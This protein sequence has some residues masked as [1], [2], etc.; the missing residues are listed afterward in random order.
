M[1]NPNW[2]AKCSPTW[3]S[4]MQQPSMDSASPQLQPHEPRNNQVRNTG[5][6]FYPHVSQES[7]PS[8]HTIIRESMVPKSSNI[9]PHNSNHADLGNSFLSLLSGPPSLL[10]RDLQQFSSPGAVVKVPVSSNIFTV[11]AAGSGV[12]LACNGIFSQPPSIENPRSGADQFPVVASRYGN[13][14]SLLDVLQ[15]GNVNHQSSEPVKA[16]VCLSDARNEKVWDF[17]S[18][19]RHSANTGKPHSK[20]TQAAQK[21]PL[22]IN[23]ST[24]PCSYTL[25]P[26]CPRVFCLGASGDLLRSD[27]GLLG[28]VCSCHGLRMS[29]SKFCQHSGVCDVNPGAAVH[30][31]SGETIAQWRKLYFHKFGIRVPED[32]N[33]WDWPEGFS[34]TAGTVKHSVTASNMPKMSDLSNVAGSRGGLVEHRQPQHNGALFKNHNTGQKSV[35]EV[36]YVGKQRNAQDGY[37]VLHKG[38][39]GASQSNFPSVVN[40]QIM[41]FHSS[42]CSTVSEFIGTR[43]PYD[44][45][46]SVSA[47]ADSNSKSGQPFIS[48][49][50]LQNSKSHGNDS[51]I[52][53]LYNL[54]KGNTVDIDAVSSGIELKLGQPSPQS[55]TLGT[56]V[57]P[58]F[59]SHPFDRHGDPRKSLLPEQLIHN[60]N[61]RGMQEHCQ[62]LQHAAGSSNTC[63]RRGQSRLNLV[64]QS[65]GI[66]NARDA[67]G[68]G[69]LNGDADRCSMLLTQC[70]TST[71]GRIYSK[72]SGGTMDNCHVIPG[73]LHCESHIAK[74]DSTSSSWT[75]GF[76]SGQLTVN[77][78]GLQGHGGKAKEA[79]FA[80][81]SL[82]VATEPNF[83]F[84]TKHRESSTTC[85]GAGCHS[86]LVVHDKSSHLYKFS[87]RPHGALD[88]RN[89]LNQSGKTH[90]LGFHGHLDHVFQQSTSSPVDSGLMLP[91]PAISLGFSSSTSTSV[92]NTAPALTIKEGN[93]VYPY[94]LDENSRMLAFRHIFELSNQVHDNA[95]LGTEQCQGVPNS[96]CR[97]N[98]HCSIVDPSSSKEDRCGLGATS[99]QVAPEVAFRALQ[100]GFTC[101]M[102]GDAENLVPTSGLSKCS[103][104]TFLAGTLLDGKAIEMQCQ[105]SC[106]MHRNEH[107]VGRSGRIENDINPSDKCGKC[108]QRVPVAY[109]PGKCVC[110]AHTSSL[111]GNCD[112]KDENFFS[113]LKEWSGSINGMASILLDRKLERNSTFS[114]EKAVSIDKS[115][116]T[117]GQVKKKVECHAFQWRDVPNK[118]TKMHNLTCNH[119]SAN[120]LDRR[121]NVGD[122]VAEAAATAKRFDT[123][124]QDAASLKEREKSN[125]SSGCSAAAVT[126]ASVKFDSLDSST[127]GGDEYTKNLVVDEGSGIDK[128]WSSDDPPDSGRSSE[129][130]GFTRNIS[131][132]CEGSSK[133]LPDQSS[134]SLIDELRL[135]DSFISKNVRNKVNKGLSSIHDKTNRTETFEKAYKSAK[136]ERPT[137][138]KRLDVSFPPAGIDNDNWHFVSAKDMQMRLQPDKGRSHNCGCSAGPNFK[139]RPGLTKTNDRRELHGLYNDC[140]GENAQIPLDTEDGCLEIPEISGRKR[141]RSG[142]TAPTTKKLQ[143][144]EPNCADTGIHAK[145]KSPE[146]KKSSSSKQ[147]GICKGQVRPVVCGMY[148][149]ISG[150]D[151]FRP[152]KIASLRKILEST[153][154]YTDAENDKL[155]KTCTKKSKKRCIRGSSGCIGKFFNFKDRDIE[156]HGDTISSKLV[157]DDS[158]KETDSGFFPLGKEHADVHNSMEEKRDDG[159][160]EDERILDTGIS[161]LL[162]PKCKE[163]RKRSLYELSIKDIKTPKCQPQI[164]CRNMGNFL[165]SAEDGKLRAD[166]LCTA[167]SDEEHQWQ[168]SISQSDAFCCVCG[169]SNKNDINCLLECSRC[170]IRVHQACYGV[171]KVPRGRWC[172]R[173]CRTSS[174]SIVCVLCGYGGGAMTRALRSRSIVKSLLKTWNIVTEFG[175][176][177]AVSPSEILEDK[178]SMLS[179]STSALERDSFPIIRPIPSEPSS[180]VVWKMDLQKQLECVKNSSCSSDNLN[181]LNSITAGVVDS[182]VKQWIH[183]VCGLWTPG[184]RCPNVDTMSAFDVSGASHPKADVV[185]SL[186]NRPGGSCIQCRVRDCSVHFHPWCAHQKGLLQSEVEGVDNENVGFYGRCMLHASYNQ[187]ETDGDPIGTETGHPGDKEYSCAR[188]EGYKGRKREGFR[189]NHPILSKGS[190]GCAV[191]QE[192]LNAWHHINKQ[193]PSPK[194]LAKLPTSDVEYDCRKE[195]ARYKQSKGWKYLV[196]YKS[197]IHALG[198]Y[199]SQFISRG[200]MVVEYVGEIVGLRVADKRESEYQSGRK[201]QY[202]SACYF[203]RID[204]EHIIDATRQ[205]GIARFVNH[206]CLPNCVAKVISVRNGKKVV[207]FAER[208]IYPGEEITYDYHFNHE[209]EGEKI[210]CFCNSKNCRRYLN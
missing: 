189:H 27:T 46:H 191:P 140:E 35:N 75:R 50:K 82:R 163:I 19:S 54:K 201:L 102:D 100:S 70:K 125:I 18:L 95:S 30:M 34:T 94:T 9:R 207:F 185:C 62:Y 162:K 187:C 20:T 101:W 203:F 131:S 132:A 124:A 7:S 3:Q 171:S 92:S 184:T 157:P 91:F 196:V 25:P 156:G 43:G 31:D 6:L 96:T 194:G 11:S 22:E 165:N 180:A 61:S 208:D 56:S 81:D 57:L 44:G 73:A 107:P 193:K 33:G 169:S 83:E 179:P 115:G 1:D 85:D 28:V 80:A 200:A 138:Q 168:S 8:A 63:G 118:A 26:G 64:S 123:S 150:G 97:D 109:V 188:T 42:G 58:A 159:S 149:A 45:C 146:F 148:G 55:Q 137:K 164:K 78:L 32:H 136:R 130:F 14:F 181:V 197:G 84:R 111:G 29:I 134:R 71:E 2:Q 17:S 106:D 120:L 12:S 155:L 98:I 147:L 66:N 51:D 60:S 112:S 135:R 172:C 142:Q 145:C 4:L 209:D 16:A 10:Q 117:D 38:L 204:K 152:P 36:S 99:K 183:M 59:T 144:E 23:C 153:R 173:P 77:K 129:I 89:P 161:T 37:N 195:Y 5:M 158:V 13:S 186:C 108:F 178:F 105:L 15:G 114:K 175:P 127:V 141:F 68:T 69:E 21:A 205:G 210:P 53:K 202:K 103:F 41:G 74:R 88:P 122:Q 166:G 198:L 121:E 48:Y 65:S 110:T 76:A 170:L 199:T 182:T 126:Q 52:S 116:N 24:S 72:A 160:E 104:S 49:K 143:V 113:A 174:K 206:S 139:Q 79:A 67:I 119:R 90:C 167:K 192:Q 47:C 87:G 39:I 40:N 190:G 93:G 154:R 177:D 86:C 128:C 133:L 151:S 176:K